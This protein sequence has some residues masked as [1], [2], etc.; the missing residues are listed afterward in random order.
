MIAFSSDFSAQPVL[1]DQPDLTQVNE[2]GPL[3]W[4]SPPAAPCTP[5]RLWL[6]RDGEWLNRQ[7]V[8]EQLKAVLRT[9]RH[10][11]CITESGDFE[12]WLTLSLL[13]GQ[14]HLLERVVLFNCLL[15]EQDMLELEQPDS[16]LLHGQV[17]TWRIQLFAQWRR[18]WPLWSDPYAYF[19]GPVPYGIMW[20]TSRRWWQRHLGVSKKP[21][22]RSG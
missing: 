2:H 4:L 5:E 21:A 3:S 16:L 22:K 19:S 15:L 9:E 10:Y 11:L 13:D 14:Y 8:G 18:R 20:R 12:S 6:L 17:N 7:V 1:T